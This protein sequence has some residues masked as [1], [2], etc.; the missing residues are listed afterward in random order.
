MPP[1]SVA[2]LDSGALASSA[3]GH[4]VRACTGG[5]A[6]CTLL[7]TVQNVIN[8]DLHWGLT[9][10]LHAPEKLDVAVKKRKKKK[11]R[12]LVSA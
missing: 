8:S 1:E 4:R 9:V 11:G 3:L 12:S 6:S 5:V 7:I 2:G 10:V